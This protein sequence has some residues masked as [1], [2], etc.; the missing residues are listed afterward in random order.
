[1]ES[2]SIELSESYD[3]GGATFAAFHSAFG[4]SC[5]FPFEGL[6]GVEDLDGSDS[7]MCQ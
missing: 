6:L 3:I 7:D 2:G 1:M 5:L 4:F